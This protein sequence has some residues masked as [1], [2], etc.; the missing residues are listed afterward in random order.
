[1]HRPL[2]PLHCLSVVCGPSSL[3][4]HLL[5]IGALASRT[6]LIFQSHQH[7]YEQKQYAK[8]PHAAKTNACNTCNTCNTCNRWQIPETPRHGLQMASTSR[9]LLPAY[10][11]DYKGQRGCRAT[12]VRV[13]HDHGGVARQDKHH[14]LKQ[15]PMSA[16]R[17]AA[18]K[19]RA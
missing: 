4:S 9:A 2:A 15:S 8:T 14:T 5:A 13:E 3:Q 19:E 18:G 11:R 6:C 7:G 1:M 10:A 16:G 12:K 17:P